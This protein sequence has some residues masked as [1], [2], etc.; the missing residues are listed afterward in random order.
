LVK[1]ESALP[2]TSYPGKD[3]IKNNRLVY[4]TEPGKAE[5]GFAFTDPES[6]PGESYYYIRVRER[7]GALASSSPIWVKR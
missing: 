6:A 7:D 2:S 4:S 3:V 1:Q 5:G